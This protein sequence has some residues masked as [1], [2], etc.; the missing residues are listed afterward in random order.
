MNRKIMLLAPFALLL[1]A[2]SIPMNTAEF[3]QAAKA[4]AALLTS[5]SFEVNRP[6]AEVASTFQEK[7][8]EC[9]N[10]KLGSA[11]RNMLGGT[12]APHYYAEAKQGV[13]M[14]KGRAELSFQVK[15]ENTLNKEPDGGSYFLVADA[16]A[17]GKKKTRVDVYRRTSVDLL[18]EALKGWAS[19]ENLGCPDPMK[20]L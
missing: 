16:Y 17:V 4:N 9:L 20:F 13:L 15:Y 10:F 18:L 19:G 6:A 2:C 3:R 1:S 7:A 5:E 14:S 8:A 12:G 11:K